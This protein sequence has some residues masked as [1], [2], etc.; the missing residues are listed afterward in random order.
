MELS[1]CGTSSIPDENSTGPVRWRFA[2]GALPAAGT[3]ATHPN[4][5]RTGLDLSSAARLGATA[6]SEQT[7]LINGRLASS[8][9]RPDVLKFTGGIRVD[10]ILG[11]RFDVIA[12]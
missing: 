2:L 10:L 9:A 12:I 1:G 8:L 6:L 4:P 7:S 11:P 3:G 5:E